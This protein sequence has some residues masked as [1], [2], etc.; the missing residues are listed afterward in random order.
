MLWSYFPGLAMFEFINQY[1][2]SFSLS[3]LF[4]LPHQLENWTSKTSLCFLVLTRNPYYITLMHINRLICININILIHINYISTMSW[5]I[6]QM[7]FSCSCQ[8]SSFTQ[9]RS[10]NGVLLL[11]D[12]AKTNKWSF[13]MKQSVGSI[14]SKY[15][16]VWQALC[17]RW[18]K[19]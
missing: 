15:T 1:H 18:R 11:T 12:D 5:N 17:Q 9:S 13:D 14:W 2:F 10:L 8:G 6:H 3:N 16:L 7:Y 19:A 4:P